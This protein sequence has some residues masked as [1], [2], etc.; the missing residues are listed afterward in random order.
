MRPVMTSGHSPANH[1]DGGSV[2][3]WSLESLCRFRP[4]RWR[5]SACGLRR[6][7]SH[8]C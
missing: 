2:T 3:S 8:R 5:F 4:I 7:E 1:R 6:A